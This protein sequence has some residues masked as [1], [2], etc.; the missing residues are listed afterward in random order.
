VRLELRRK[1]HPYRTLVELADALDVTI[2]R[3]KRH[4]RELEGKDDLSLESLAASF[5]TAPPPSRDDLFQLFHAHNLCLV[6]GSPLEKVKDRQAGWGEFRQCAF[7]QFSMHENADFERT[8]QVADAQLDELQD[9]LARAQRILS[10]R[11]KRGR[12]LA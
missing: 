11:K 10:Q 3:L 1:L 6:C 8:R 12:A 2:P 9:S 4:L 7:C 5:G